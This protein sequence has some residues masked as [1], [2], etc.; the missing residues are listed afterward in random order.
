[1]PLQKVQN[2]SHSKLME[3]RDEKVEIV[4]LDVLT[5]AMD[6][7]VVELDVDRYEKADDMKRR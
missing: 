1:M 3:F 4:G 6:V 7:D 5:V 2:Y